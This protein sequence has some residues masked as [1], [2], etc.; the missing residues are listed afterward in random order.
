MTII[1]QGKK[2][3]PSAMLLSHNGPTLKYGD[4]IVYSGNY[5]GLVFGWFIG[6]SP[7]GKTTYVL[8]SSGNVVSPFYNPTKFNWSS[9]IN[10][11][12]VANI[13]ELFEL[14]EKYRP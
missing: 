10:D 9:G 6:M 3:N 8:S 7:T 4:M 12:R 11:L 14:V 2:I 1:I 5:N 13:D